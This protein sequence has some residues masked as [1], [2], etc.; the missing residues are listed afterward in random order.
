[1]IEIDQHHDAC[2]GGNA[3]ERNEAYAYRDAEN[4]VLSTWPGFHLTWV[5]YL[6][7]VSVTLQLALSL[8][9]L[10]REFRLRLPAPLVP[11]V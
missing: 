2:L 10:N 8:W 6:T 7:V 3:C 4:V 1:M 9:L 11:A 5:W